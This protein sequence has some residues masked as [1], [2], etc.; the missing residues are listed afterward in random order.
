MKRFEIDENDP[1]TPL[2]RMLAGDWYRADDPEIQAAFR[3]GRQI[4]TT[5]FSPEQLQVM[6]RSLVNAPLRLLQRDMQ[7]SCL[8]PLLRAPPL[9]YVRIG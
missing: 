4:N 7:R 5:N 3:S 8:L 6:G 9:P 1:R 2:E